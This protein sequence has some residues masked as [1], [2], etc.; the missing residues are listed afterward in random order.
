ME[1]RYWHEMAR[2]EKEE[3]AGQITIGQ[4]LETYLQP[5]WCE[6]PEA[7][8]GAMGC[9]SLMDTDKVITR[10]FCRNCDCFREG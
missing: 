10:D 6:Y 5:D 4:L 9:W 1:K 8:G 2:E 3:L 7:L